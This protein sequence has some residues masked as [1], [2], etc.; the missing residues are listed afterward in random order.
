MIG[1]EVRSIVRQSVHADMLAYCNVLS[2]PPP[3]PLPS[4]FFPF[5]GG[6]KMMKRRKIQKVEMIRKKRINKYQSSNVNT[7]YIIFLICISMYFLL[8][9]T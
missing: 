6:Y 7:L 5:R 9:I 2:P 1:S 8:R 3:P 4:T